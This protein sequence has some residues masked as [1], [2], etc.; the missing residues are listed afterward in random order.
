[1]FN[2]YL[3]G[4]DIF[5]VILNLIGVAGAIY[6]NVKASKNGVFSKTM[7]KVASLAGVYFVAYC[8]LLFS[9]INPAHWSSIFRGLAVLVWW[10]VWILPARSWYKEGHGVSKELENKIY[11]R[12]DSWGIGDK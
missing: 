7:H 8:I 11:E 5:I 4:I 6:W 12:I 9:E 3:A 1:M 10:Y 2:S